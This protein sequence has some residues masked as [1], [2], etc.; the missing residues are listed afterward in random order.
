MKMTQADYRDINKT[1]YNAMPHDRH[2]QCGIT[3]SPQCPVCAQKRGNPRKPPFAAPPEQPI[4]ASY[5]R[6][7]MAHR[8]G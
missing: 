8:R 3:H 2:V 5:R 6:G 1:D 7:R 4:P